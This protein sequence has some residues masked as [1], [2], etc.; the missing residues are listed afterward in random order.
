MEHND[1]GEWGELVARDFLKQKGYFV[2]CLDW[3]DKHRD[4]DIVA[5]DNETKEVV[6]V[7]VKTR[8]NT[9]FGNPE[10]AVDHAKVLNLKK[11]ANAYLHINRIT[12][13]YRFDIIAVVGVCDENVQIKH[14]KNVIY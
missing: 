5:I 14:L 7:E 2:K 3:R 12:R 11:A 1:L 4:L 13:N 9:L 8:K 6:F 10:D